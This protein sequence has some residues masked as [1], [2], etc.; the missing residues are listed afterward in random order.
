MFLVLYVE[1]I[2]SF[3]IL[4]IIHLFL[5]KQESHEHPLTIKN[6]NF[7]FKH[8]FWLNINNALNLEHKLNYLFWTLKNVLKH[9]PI[10]IFL[11]AYIK[12][13]FSFSWIQNQV[14]LNRIRSETLLQ[15]FQ[16]EIET[17]IS[18]CHSKPFFIRWK[19]LQN[20]MWN[21]LS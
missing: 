9:W 19:Y 21:R 11:L 17:S 8:C 5:L 16:Y 15:I 12:I 1:Q 7:I 14:L 20:L 10:N 18:P 6:I 13:M 3:K 4:L 2:P